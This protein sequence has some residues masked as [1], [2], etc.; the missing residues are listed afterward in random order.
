MTTTTPSLSQSEPKKRAALKSEKPASSSTKKRKKDD[1]IGI[2]SDEE[3]AE[4][5]EHQKCCICLEVPTPED[6]AKLD[7]CSHTYCFSCIETWSERENSCP[8]CKARFT[9]IERM[10]PIPSSKKRKGGKSERPQNVKRVKRRDQSSD[11]MQPF[12]HLFAGMDNVHN[13]PQFAQLILNGLNG[14]PRASWEP[15][16]PT[17]LMDI[18]SNR[19]ATE[20]AQSSALRPPAERL[21]LGVPRRTS[22]SS[23]TSGEN[24][25]RSANFSRNFDI[26]R[27]RIMTSIG[28]D[29]VERQRRVDQIIRNVTNRRALERQNRLSEDVR[30]R[31]TEN[32]E[33]GSGLLYRPNT[34]GSD[35]LRD[36]SRNLQQS[37]EI[38]FPTNTSDVAR[39]RSLQ[40]ASGTRADSPHPFNREA[41]TTFRNTNATMG[42]PSPNM[43]NGAPT[44]ERLQNNNA[45]RSADDPLEILDSDDESCDDVVEVV[46]VN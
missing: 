36:L 46:V 45:G 20:G 16:R 24:Q 26:Q 5:E 31:N 10:N 4:P 13:M 39:G 14:P 29:A 30:H 27:P 6:R 38:S 43:N 37:G 18:I 41:S 12:H 40:T 17:T 35:L 11:F 3:K 33:S 2:G 15:A 32:F 25:A 21:D 7:S 23:R 19:T 22:Q 34:F 1:C 42:F 9:K 8:Q 44:R 28:M